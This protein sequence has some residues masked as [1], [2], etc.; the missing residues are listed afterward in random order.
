MINFAQCNVNSAGAPGCNG[1]NHNRL[2]GILLVGILS[3]HVLTTRILNGRMTQ[4][5][6]VTRNLDNML[7]RTAYTYSGSLRIT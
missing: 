2:L 6:T 3:S 5:H 1:I 7:Y 4:C